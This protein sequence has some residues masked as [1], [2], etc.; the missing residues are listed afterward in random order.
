MVVMG[1]SNL[2]AVWARAYGGYLTLEASG[3]ASASERANALTT[4]TNARHA[5]LAEQEA[6]VERAC[7]SAEATLDY[8]AGRMRLEASVNPIFAAA[9]ADGYLA[10]AKFRR[11][12][13]S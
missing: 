11:E 6:I 5:F 4:A 3:T 7:A 1:D 2:R 10:L 13:Q 9:I 12:A 8:A